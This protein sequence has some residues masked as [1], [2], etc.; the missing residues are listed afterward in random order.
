MLAA[1]LFAVII[2]TWWLPLEVEK[3]EYKVAKVWLE[4]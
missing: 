1:F 2:F 3:R 4:V